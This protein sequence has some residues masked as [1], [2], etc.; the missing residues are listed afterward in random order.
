MLSSVRSASRQPCSPSYSADFAVLRPSRHTRV[1]LRGRV[2]SKSA[3]LSQVAPGLRPQNRPRMAP[4]VEFVASRLRAYGATRASLPRFAAVCRGVSPPVIP[5]YC[6]AEYRFIVSR[7]PDAETLASSRRRNAQL[8]IASPRPLLS[9]FFASLR[10][11]V[12]PEKGDF[13]VGF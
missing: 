7:A 10:D 6:F 12:P 1:C 4:L 9:S 2:L 3:A 8:A 11:L 13:R 5:R